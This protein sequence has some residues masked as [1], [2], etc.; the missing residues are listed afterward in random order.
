MSFYEHIFC[1]KSIIFLVLISISSYEH[2]TQ[3]AAHMKYISYEAG[4][5][6]PRKEKR[7]NKLH[8]STVSKKSDNIL[9]EN[10]QID[11]LDRRTGK[12]LI[13]FDKEPSGTQKLPFS[14][15]AGFL[16]IYLPKPGCYKHFPMSK[17]APSSSTH[18]TQ[19]FSSFLQPNVPFLVCC[20]M[21]LK[22]IGSRYASR[23]AYQH[24]Y[25]QFS[26]F[27]FRNALFSIH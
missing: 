24:I 25:A 23:T 27:K 9:S 14:N 2:W 3:C 8:S 5:W 17:S 12:K 1:R 22:S 10:L 11:I 20:L 7:V 16:E 21:N 18:C 4:F 13:T 26:S 6:Y 15:F 19:R